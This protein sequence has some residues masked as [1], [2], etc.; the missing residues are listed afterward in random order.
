MRRGRSRSGL[1]T[2]ALSLVAAACGGGEDL[3]EDAGDHRA[4]RD[5]RGGRP[6]R[7]DGRGRGHLDRGRAGALREVL[8]VFA[9]ET[10]ATVRFRSAGDDIAA[11]VGPRIEGGDPPDVAILPQPGVVQTFAGQGD[12]IADRGRRRRRRSTRTSRRRRAARSARSTARCTACGSRRP[13]SRPSGTTGRLR[14]RRRRAARDLGRAADRSRRP[15]RTTASSRY[16]VGADVGWPLTDLFENIYLRTA[17]PEMYDQL[18]AHEIPWTDQSV[19]DALTVMATCSADDPARGRHD[20]RRADRLHRV[21]DAGVR[22]PA[23]RARSC[24]RATSSAAS[25]PARRTPKVGTDADFFEFP[26]IDGSEPA[27]MGGGDFAVLLDDTEGGQALMEYLATPEAAEVWAAEGGFI[28]PNKQVDASVVPRRGHP[29]RRAGADRR[30]RQRPLR[31]VRP[32]ADRVRRHD[33]AGH[34]GHP[35]RLPAQPRRRGRH[36]AGARGGGEEGV[37]GVTA[38]S[39]RLGAR[40]PAG[41]GRTWAAGLFLAPALV[42]L[43]ALVVY[44]IFFSVGPQPLRRERQRVR[45]RRQLPRDVHAQATLH[46]DQEQP[47]LGGVRAELV[48]AL[49]LVFAVLTERVRWGTAFKVAIFMPMA[50]SFLSAGVILRLVYE[51]DPDRGLANAALG[52]VVDVFRPPGEL[53]GARP[54]QEEAVVEPATAASRRPSPSTPGDDRDA[55]ARRR[56]RPSSARPARRRP[57][58]ARRGERRH[59]RHRLARLHA[60]RRRRAGRDRPGGAGLPGVE[61]EAVADGGG[62]GVGDHRRRRHVRARGLEPGAYKLRLPA[63]NFREPFGGVTWLGPTLVTPAI[64]VVLHL[65]LGRLRDGGDRGGAGGDP[66]RDAR[67]R[68]GR[69]RQR[70]AG[71]PPGHRAAAGAGARRRAR[72]AGDQRAEDL[73]PRARDRARI[74]AGR[75]QRDRAAAVED[76]VRHPRLRPRQRAG[77]VPAAAGGAGDGLQH[78]AV[79]ARSSHDAPSTATTPGRPPS[80]GAPRSSPARRHADA[81]PRDRAARRRGAAL[82]GADD[83]PARGVVPHAADNAESGWWTALTAPAQLTLQPYRDLLDDPT[84]VSGLRGTRC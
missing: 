42:L 14:G 64:I 18:A 37:R 67:G 57:S 80:R 81:G 10:G 22:R 72:D 50:I 5:G 62:R 71:V 15:S 20:G 47:D 65:D 70:V 78:P 76:G 83:R 17:G 23:R 68:A 4:R 28:S 33:R 30:G 63:S 75:R 1:A 55:R 40:G 56:S 58:R 31:P 82:A 39:R 51:E 32:A 7:P 6:E 73:R 43:G 77:R 12:L 46:R 24:S 34:L 9:E 61:V 74:G 26:S 44:P 35:D 53:A 59:R 52:A 3:D 54:S 19:K 41:R 25:S 49:G 2:V 21:G 29:A 84:I 38:V 16:S 27:V 69:R 36:G 60:G 79:P 48:T 66:A 11:F 45:R 8:D 13:R